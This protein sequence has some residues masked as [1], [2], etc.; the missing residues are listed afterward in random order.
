MDVNRNICVCSAFTVLSLGG[1]AGN[2]IR[3][4]CRINTVLMYAAD[5][6]SF[7]KEISK[8]DSDIVAALK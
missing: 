6:S 2:S 7:R 3:S 5:V 1:Q 8:E 4:L